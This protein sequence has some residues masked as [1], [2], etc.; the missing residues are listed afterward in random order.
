M[1]IQTRNTHG[2]LLLIN[3][4]QIEYV[5]QQNDGDC[6]IKMQSGTNHKLSYNE[7]EKFL[8]LTTAE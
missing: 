3:T 2:E 6:F 7:A 1:F 4:N 5:L 8:N